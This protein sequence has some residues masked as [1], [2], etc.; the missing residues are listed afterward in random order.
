VVAEQSNSGG[1]ETGGPEA[2]GPLQRAGTMM[3]EGSAAVPPWAIWLKLSSQL[4]EILLRFDA[5]CLRSIL[6]TIKS[7]L[8]ADAGAGP[9][10]RRGWG[11][12]RPS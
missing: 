7:W 11:R 6:L 9:G 12:R 3:P 8:G 2:G 1:P 5:L 4:A 10:A